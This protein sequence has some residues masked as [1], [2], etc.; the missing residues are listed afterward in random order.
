MKT[1]IFDN[2]DPQGRS[3]IGLDTRITLGVPP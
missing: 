1:E 3:F 2:G